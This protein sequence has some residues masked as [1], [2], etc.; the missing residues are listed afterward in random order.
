[1]PGVDRLEDEVVD[2]THPGGHHLGV[3][4]VRLQRE[5]LFSERQDA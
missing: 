3:V 4:A 2:E 5:V 1:V